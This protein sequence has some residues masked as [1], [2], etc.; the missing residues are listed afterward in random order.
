MSGA[1]GTEAGAKR[2]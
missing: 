2:N 1:L